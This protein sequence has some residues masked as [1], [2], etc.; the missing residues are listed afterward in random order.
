MGCLQSVP[1]RLEEKLEK[2]IT[3]SSFLNQD[4][5]MPVAQNAWK[6]RYKIPGKAAPKVAKAEELYRRVRV[7][8][9]N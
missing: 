7:I 3:P 1:G 4:V 5:W 2:V 6:P 8:R 9:A